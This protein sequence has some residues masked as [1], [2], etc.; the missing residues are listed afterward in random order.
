MFSIFSLKG[1][2]VLVTVGSLAGFF[3]G[4]SVRDAFCDAAAAKIEV[5]SLKRQLAARDNAMK[6]D[7]ELLE[8]QTLELIELERKV[9]ALQITAGECLPAADADRVRGLWNR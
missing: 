7:A 5:A 2:A 4:W 1:I 8:K 6:A 9:D 3:G